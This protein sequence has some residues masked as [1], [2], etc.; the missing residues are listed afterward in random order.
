MAFAIA[1]LLAFSLR[2]FPPGAPGVHAD[3]ASTAKE[4][5]GGLLPHFEAVGVLLLAALVAG[6]A[7]VQGG[8]RE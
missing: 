5:L 4:L 7:I 3:V 2:G 6:L 8:D 1:V